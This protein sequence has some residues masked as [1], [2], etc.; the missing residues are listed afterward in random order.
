[1]KNVGLQAGSADLVPGRL[2]SGLT[3]PNSVYSGN[4]RWNLSDGQVDGTQIRYCR[5]RGDPERL[6]NFHETKESRSKSSD[7]RR[8]VSSRYRNDY[9]ACRRRYEPTATPMQPRPSRANEEGSG[10]DTL[11]PSAV[12][13][14]VKVGSVTL[15]LVPLA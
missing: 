1:M 8:I 10:T 2:S 13:P 3:S 5:G 15:M 14:A 7:F 12:F 11:N 9:A 6:G 4:H